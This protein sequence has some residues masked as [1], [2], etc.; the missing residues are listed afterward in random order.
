MFYQKLC[1]MLSFVKNRLACNQDLVCPWSLDLNVLANIC[2]A[3]KDSS[4]SIINIGFSIFLN[5]YESTCS[6]AKDL[7]VLNILFDSR[8]YFF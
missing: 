2:I 8:L 5:R 3:N 1:S 4:L 7:K 6:A